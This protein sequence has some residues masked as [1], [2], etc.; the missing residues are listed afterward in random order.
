MGNP[1]EPIV[2]SLCVSSQRLHSNTSHPNSL[3]HRGLTIWTIPRELMTITASLLSSTCE[4]SPPSS[5]P[6]PSPSCSDACS[7]F[8]ASS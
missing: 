2:P 8:D 6:K 4:V 7:S 1:T 5:T 3:A